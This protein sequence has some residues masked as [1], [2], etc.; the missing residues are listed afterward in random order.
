MTP[1]HRYTW[2]FPLLTV[3]AAHPLE[4]TDLPNLLRSD[5][6]RINAEKF[7]NLMEETS[8]SSLSVRGRLLRILYSIELYT[9]TIAGLNMF[10]GGLLGFV[11]PLA[12]E[13]V[14]HLNLTAYHTFCYTL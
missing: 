12:L 10:V 1:H 2:I 13:G 9:M 11:G 3:G 5:E 8:S 14:C 6:A 7:E 4:M